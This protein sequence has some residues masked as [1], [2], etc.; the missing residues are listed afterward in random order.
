MPRPVWTR[1]SLLCFSY[2]NKRNTGNQTGDKLFKNLYIYECPKR[3]KCYTCFK[4]IFK[5]FLSTEKFP[6]FFK[7]IKESGYMSRTWGYLGD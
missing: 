1:H 4:K 2:I 3:E 5:Y 6:F 7:K